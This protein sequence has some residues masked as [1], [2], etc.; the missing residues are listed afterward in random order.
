VYPQ[1]QVWFTNLNTVPII[2]LRLRKVNVP[3][4]FVSNMFG[5]QGGFLPLHSGSLGSQ[6]GAFLGFIWCSRALAGLL[7]V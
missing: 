2:G 6:V 4:V 7:P 1:S 3:K 5:D